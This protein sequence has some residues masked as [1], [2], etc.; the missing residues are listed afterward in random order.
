MVTLA[1]MM[2]H[3][4]MKT[5]NDLEIKKMEHCIG[6]R[7]EK[8]YHRSGGAYFKPFRNHFSPGGTD[9]KIWEG[10]K[11]KGFAECGEDQK[12]YWLNRSGLNILSAVEE[13]FIY[14]DSANGNVI[15]AQYDVL[16][17]LLDDA[18]FCGYECWLPSSSRAIALRARLPRRLANE[19]LKY[20]Q[21]KR[22]YVKH[23]YV[24]GCDD[25][26]FPHCTH[27]WILTKKWKDEHAEELQRRQ[28]EE[29]KR[30]D[31][32]EYPEW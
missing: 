5:L 21:D 10:L 13:V 26:G 3:K 27:G 12:Y 29:Y 22:E 9:V 20:L 6:Y 25:G 24:G 32:G 31:T 18:V 1:D 7:P 2:H 15:D 23:V 4:A 28:K 17:V 8:V 19:T 11:E 30:M 14:S 16:E